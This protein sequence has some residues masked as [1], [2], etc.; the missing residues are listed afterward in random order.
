[1]SPLPIAVPTGD[2]EAYEYVGGELR[3]LVRNPDRDAAMRA[4]G[5]LGAGRVGALVQGDTLL[6]GHNAHDKAALVR[7]ERKFAALRANVTAPAS[8]PTRAPALQVVTD[9]VSTA[10][11]VRRPARVDPDLCAHCDEPAPRHLTTCPE[12]ATA[13]PP[14]PVD[15]ARRWP[16]P[17]SRGS[18]VPPHRE[19]FGARVLERERHEAFAESQ[20][21]LAAD[22]GPATAAELEEADDTADAPIADDTTPITAPETPMPKPK[23]TPKPAQRRPAKRAT[24]STDVPV[25]TCGAKDCKAPRAGVRIDTAEC[26]RD[27]CRGHR[28]RAGGRAHD[29]Q[30]TLEA[31]AQTL[32]DGTTERPEG[33]AP[34]RTPRAIVR[35]GRPKTA[36][37]SV[38]RV[39]RG[40]DTT[41]DFTA[42]LVRELRGLFARQLT[43]ERVK[44]IVTEVLLDVV[45]RVGAAA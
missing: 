32:R 42:V 7:M 43:E 33:S 8:A 37:P 19:G 45:R 12:A 5:R 3:L 44:A 40:A 13:P 22:P 10:P 29:W 34:P 6:R 41:E 14:R 15:D 2:F 24:T 4:L 18:G 1:M 31:A 23:K 11:K 21:E 25:E 38:A 36:A 9:A 27:L 20:R 16:A 39:E 17:A 30:C 28:M 26:V 35:R